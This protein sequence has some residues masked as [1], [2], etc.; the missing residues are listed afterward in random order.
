[1]FKMGSNRQSRGV[2]IKVKIQPRGTPTTIAR[3]VARAV[4]FTVSNHTLDLKPLG[5]SG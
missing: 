3:V 5:F 1:M 4:R 2:A